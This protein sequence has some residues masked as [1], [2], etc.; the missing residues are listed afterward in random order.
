MLLHTHACVHK[1]GMGRTRTRRRMRPRACVRPRARDASVALGPLARAER[2]L[3][4]A[5]GGTLG[6]AAVGASTCVAV[7][8]RPPHQHPQGDAGLRA[9]SCSAA[10]RSR[11]APH[12]RAAAPHSSASACVRARMRWW[13]EE[14]RRC[15]DKLADARSHSRSLAR[16]LAH[17]LRHAPYVH[18]RAC[19]RAWRVRACAHACVGVCV[20]KGVCALARHE[21]GEAR[22]G[23]G[24]GGPPGWARVS[25]AG[26]RWGRGA[27]GRV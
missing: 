8:A 19:E 22:A 3:T 10:A 27:R 1:R 7:A 5:G 11:R 17:T 21:W 16:T 14:R 26:G 24:D 23:R 15:P 6:C 13:A 2:V 20:Q 4:E 12:A 25:G 9:A 18:V